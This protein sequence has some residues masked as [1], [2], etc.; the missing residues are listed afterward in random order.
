ML[1]SNE[2]QKADDLKAELA[3]EPD[4]TSREL[5]WLRLLGQVEIRERDLSPGVGVA[6]ESEEAEAVEV[7][8]KSLL[9]APQLPFLGLSARPRLELIPG[10]RFKLRL[11]CR[12]ML[13]SSPVAEGRLPRL[14]EFLVLF[15]PMALRLTLDE[16]P[17]RDLEG[18]MLPPGRVEGV[19]RLSKAD[20]DWVEPWLLPG[21]QRPL[22]VTGPGV[23]AE[24][25]SEVEEVIRLWYW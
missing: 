7:V 15:F 24:L 9:R 11:R 3:P 23:A 2:R 5:R 1:Q 22:C 19:L 25:R 12:L 18:V 6:D 8:E 16:F 13:K 21:V 14:I 4:G 10:L 20:R 17:N